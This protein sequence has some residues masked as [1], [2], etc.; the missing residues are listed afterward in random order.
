[1]A[2]ELVENMIAGMPS[3]FQRPKYRVGYDFYTRKNEIFFDTFSQY[4]NWLVVMEENFGEFFR[5]N[6]ILT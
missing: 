2:G 5:V 3:N 6:A 4:Q 1:M